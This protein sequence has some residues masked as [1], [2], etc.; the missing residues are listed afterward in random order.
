MAHLSEEEKLR[1]RESNQCVLGTHAMEGMFPDAATL[2]LMDRYA[3]GELTR[4]QLSSAID[5]NVE[6]TLAGKRT[7]TVRVVEAQAEHSIA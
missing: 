3:E 6:A 4:E 1:R 5:R 7:E 2:S